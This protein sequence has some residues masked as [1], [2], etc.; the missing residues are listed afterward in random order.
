MDR[1]SFSTRLTSRQRSLTAWRWRLGCGR[2]W[3]V[4]GFWHGHAVVFPGISPMGSAVSLSRIGL[5]DNRASEFSGGRSGGVASDA[6]T[7]TGGSGARNITFFKNSSLYPAHGWRRV[8]ALGKSDQR[9]PA[10][11][12]TA[13]S[14]WSALGMDGVVTLVESRKT[15][16]PSRAGLTKRSQPGMIFRAARVPASPRAGLL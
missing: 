16:L 14:V 3:R 7:I 5:P 9:W 4:Y 6:R 12:S 13:S 11:P 15:I 1:L 10:Q 8:S 2:E